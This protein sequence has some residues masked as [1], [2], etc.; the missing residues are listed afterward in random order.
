MY[1]FS[2][3]IYINEELNCSEPSSSFS[4]PWIITREGKARW[5]AHSLHSEK[6]LNVKN[7]QAYLIP[8]IDNDILFVTKST[9]PI[10]IYHIIF[11]L[12]ITQQK[13]NVS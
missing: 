12:N 7:A 3:T 4:I 2:K 6:I 11:L 8:R 5:L 1:L 10:R 9:K 13:N